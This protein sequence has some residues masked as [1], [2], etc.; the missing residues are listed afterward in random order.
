MRTT[1]TIGSSSTGRTR[2]WRLVSL[3]AATLLAWTGAMAQDGA[4]AGPLVVPAFRQADRVAVITVEGGIDAI[5]AMSVRRRIA[6]AESAG[7]NAMVFEIN[8]PG[9][10]VGAVLEITNAIKGSSIDNT[11]AW[12]NPDAYSGG[13]IVAL[14]CREIVTN[15]PASMGDAFPVTLTRVP[16]QNRMGLRGLTPD[17]RTKLLPVLLADV[18]DSAR[19]NG[20]DEY[21]VQAVVIDGIE[22]WWVR[23]RADGREMAVNE[24]EFKMLFGRMPVRGRPLLAGVTGGVR[25]GPGAAE[26]EPAGASDGSD[27]SDGMGGVGNAPDGLSEEGAS[28]PGPRPSAGPREADDR[29]FRPA[30]DAL[31]DVARELE[32]PERSDL[33]LERPSQRPVL[34]PD[35]AGRFD[36]LGYLTDGSAPIVLRDD[37]MLRFGFATEVVRDDA[38]LLAYFG[39][40]ELERARENWSERLVRFMTG[41]MVRAVLI[42]VMLLALFIEMMSP[43][44]TV[45]GITAAA[46]L[47]LLLAPPA[48]I[49]MAGW[50]E[51]V[52]IGIGVVLLALELFVL[53]GFGVFGVLGVVALFAGLLGTFIPSGGSLSDP[54]TQQ[55]LLR[56]ATIILLSVITAGIGMYLLARHFDRVPI[57]DRLVLGATVN[58]E[59]ESAR[60]DAELLRAASRAP[61]LRPEPGMRGVATTALRPIGVAEIDGRLTDVVADVGV[62]DPG[63][64]VRVVRVEGFRVVV[65]EDTGGT[66]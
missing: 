2:V 40:L 26:G 20:W 62:I 65:E 14:A 11:V 41:G 61:S 38:E 8:S 43:G 5:T 3:L 39:A 27:G 19:R 50:W 31:D 53:P 33:R 34:T 17:E 59:E 55:D 44:L 15:S 64:P 57:L 48:L 7:M 28:E 22:L 45:P 9:G 24:E 58:E 25:S 37:Q 10:E 47:V 4:G 56:G 32:S 29:A 42:V 54:S 49:G 16:G 66:V 18:T 60:A 51:I 23:D 12:V 63:T 13:A 36:D 30:S 21:M 6:A 35:D 52:A 1:H 46:A